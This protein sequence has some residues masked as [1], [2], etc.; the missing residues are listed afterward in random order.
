MKFWLYLVVCEY[1]YKEKKPFEKRIS[2]LPKG[3]LTFT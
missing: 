3:S 2:P 1:P